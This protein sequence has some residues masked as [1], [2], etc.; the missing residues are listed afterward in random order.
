MAGETLKE[1]IINQIIRIEGG[2]VDDPS[3]SGGETNFGITVAVARHN[4][5]IG[6][7][8]CMPRKVAFDI[9]SA[10]Y[11]HAVRGDVLADLSESIAEEVIDTAVNMGPTRAGKFLQRTLNVFNKRESFYRDLKVDGVIG[12]ATLI[13][14]HSYLVIRDEKTIVKAL[15]CLQGAYYI[16]LSESREKDEQFVYGWF[17]NRVKL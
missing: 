13:A 11:W 14:L 6:S 15:N 5:Y 8:E 3:D 16:T 9:Y 12:K 1:R 10:K 2:Y 7:M 17:K 4:G